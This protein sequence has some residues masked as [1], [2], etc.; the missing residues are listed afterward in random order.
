MG[1]NLRPETVTQLETDISQSEVETQDVEDTTQKGDG[2]SPQTQQTNT[3]QAPPTDDKTSQLMNLYAERMKEQQRE[4][5]RL[6]QQQEKIQ[7]QQNSQPAAPSLTPD[8]A[9]ERFFNDP[10]GVLQE[11]QNNIKK[12]LQETVKPL[13]EFAQSFKRE[14]AYEGAKTKVKQNPMVAAQWDPAIESFMDQAVSSG[15]VNTDEQTLLGVAIQAIG[16]KA[17]GMLPGSQPQQSNNPTPTPTPTPTNV[18]HN[19][20]NIRPS[21]PPAPNRTQQ[22]RPRQLTELE[23]RLA[24][25]QGMTEAQYLDW[26]AVDATEVVDATIGKPP[27]PQK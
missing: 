11:Q 2:Q 20:P 27:T 1:A 10:L 7:E 8:Q 12:E 14:S 15:Q 21:A 9:R 6:R 5:D 22:N 16:L 19:P 3:Q 23:K 4:I 13:L 17:V 24:R 25:E 18:T 26:L